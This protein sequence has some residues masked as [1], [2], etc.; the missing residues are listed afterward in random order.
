MKNSK[1]AGNVGHQKRPTAGSMYEE[2]SPGK[3]MGQVSS[4]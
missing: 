2:E 3:G 1:T 4:R